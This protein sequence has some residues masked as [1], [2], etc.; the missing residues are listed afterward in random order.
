MLFHL[1][2]MLLYT[3]LSLC[4]ALF[5]L[6]FCL[7]KTPIHLF[8]DLGE[9]LIHRFFCSFMTLIHLLH[10]L[11][12]CDGFSILLLNFNTLLHFSTA[13]FHLFDFRST[14]LCTRF[15]GCSAA[16]LHLFI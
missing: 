1:R 4:T 5:H 9:T 15:C 11:I 6:F 10:L 16:H 14:A 12:D 7:G 3:L 2:T 8:F 13:G